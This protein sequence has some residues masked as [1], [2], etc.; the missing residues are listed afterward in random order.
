MRIVNFKISQNWD[1]IKSLDDLIKDAKFIFQN[2]GYKGR[3]PRIVLNNPIDGFDVIE[4]DYD[5]YGLITNGI[6]KFNSQ[7]GDSIIDSSKDI[8]GSIEQFLRD[9]SL[10]EFISYGAMD[11]NTFNKLHPEF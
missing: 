7:W 9:E 10:T 4:I 1:C 2:D 5:R 3:R 11:L 6:A 8:E